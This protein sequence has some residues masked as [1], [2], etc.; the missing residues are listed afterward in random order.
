MKGFEAIMSMTPTLVTADELS[1]PPEDDFR[2]ELIS[3]IA[4]AHWR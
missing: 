3:C 2:Y 1:M 4:S